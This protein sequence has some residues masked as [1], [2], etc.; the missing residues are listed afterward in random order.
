LITAPYS[1]SKFDRTTSHTVSGNTCLYFSHA[2][3]LIE[4][5]LP[6]GKDQSGPDPLRS[7]GRHGENFSRQQQILPPFTGQQQRA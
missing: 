3:L 2:S 7:G 5:I 4:K 1:C 6:Y